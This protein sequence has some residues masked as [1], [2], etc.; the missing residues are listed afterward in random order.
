[1]CS[2][3]ELSVY[4]QDNTGIWVHSVK[5]PKEGMDVHT[6]TH[7]ENSLER[8][9]K[10]L[11]EINSGKGTEDKTEF[12]NIHLKKNSLQQ[13][14]TTFIIENAISNRDV[15]KIKSEIKVWTVGWTMA[16]NMWER[17][18]RC[19]CSF[20]VFQVSLSLQ[21][22]THIQCKVS[23][24]HVWLPGHFHSSLSSSSRSIRCP[25]GPALQRGWF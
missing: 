1:M 25:R 18:N 17:W 5:K 10:L 21:R 23:G 19:L 13:I 8:Y 16:Q 20:P 2:L 22:N 6:C 11:T 15:K 24:G 9:A 14:C 4:V 3:M 12:K 7:R